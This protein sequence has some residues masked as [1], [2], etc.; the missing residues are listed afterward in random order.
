MLMLSAGLILPG[1]AQAAT[2][3]RKGDGLLTAISSGFAPNA[4]S[5][6]VPPIRKTATANVLGI[7]HYPTCQAGLLKTIIY[8]VWSA[9][10][11][12]DAARKRDHRPRLPA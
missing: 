11:D 1:G 10:R 5:L 6:R 12:L 3:F 8:C 4:A 2:L 9:G 7:K